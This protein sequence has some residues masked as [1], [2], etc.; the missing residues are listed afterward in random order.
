MASKKNKMAT[1]F[2]TFATQLRIIIETPATEYATTCNKNF[3][4]QTLYE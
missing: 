1:N 3:I 4:V 2:Q